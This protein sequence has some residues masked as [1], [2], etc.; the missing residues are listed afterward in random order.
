MKVLQVIE[1]LTRGGAERLVVELA[2][3]YAARGV[4]SKVLCLSTPGPWAALLEAKGLYAG[5]LGKRPGVD[6]GIAG[7]LR[8]RLDE[9]SPDIVHTHLFTANLWTRLACLGRRRRLVVTL[10]NVDN[11]RRMRH[12]RV[13]RLLWLAADRYVAV[14]PAVR[15]YYLAQGV[16]PARLREIPNGIRWDGLAGPEPLLRARPLIR[17][18]GRLVPQKGFDILVDAAKIL[19]DRSGKPV[20]RG[21]A[22]GFQVEII[23]DGPERTSLEE[24]IE[25]LRLRA[26]VSLLGGRDDARE[27]IADADIFILPSTREGLPLVLLEALHAGRPV[28]ATSLPALAGVVSDGIDAVLVEPGSAR[29]LSDAIEGLAADP[30]RARVLAAAGRAR[31]RDSYTIERAAAGYL[32][33]Y[34]ELLMERGV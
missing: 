21:M 4:D 12:R 23:G 8:R 13:D 25:R 18:C 31:A 28:I 22:G 19:S 17:A 32:A 24:R 29:A 1:S 11:W 5:C 10:H 14:G 26:E 7:R 30:A 3:E 27:L 33:L 34:N 6:V 16:P 9:I 15:D 2:E 20:N